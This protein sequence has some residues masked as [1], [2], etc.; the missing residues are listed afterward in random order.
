MLRLSVVNMSLFL[1]ISIARAAG[2]D[3]SGAG[4]PFLIATCTD[5]TVS[6]SYE[7]LVK[8]YATA[9]GG[10][11][12]P[13]VDQLKSTQGSWLD[14]AARV[15][16]DNAEPLPG[17][18]TLSESE[19]LAS[20]FEARVA[21]L[22]ASRMEGDYRFYPW[23]RYLVE[24]APPAGGV[25]IP[26][27]KHFETVMI[28]GFGDV[29]NA[30]NAMS[31]QLRTHIALEE[32]SDHL[33][34]GSS[35]KLTPGNTDLDIDS[36]TTVETVTMDRIS[37]ITRDEIYLHGAPHPNLFLSHRHFLIHE[38][39]LLTQ[40]DIFSGAD[41]QAVLGKFVVEKLKL[42]LGDGYF[43]SDQDVTA[44]AADPLHWDFSPEGLIVNFNPYE[45]ASYA[46]GFIAVTVPWSDL[47]SE[48]TKGALEIATY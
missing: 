35:E 22:E 27:T 16:G 48:M 36:S 20:T 41:W 45:V 23:E 13:I 11:S 3:C 5:R 32:T 24:K 44:T 25:D 21:A 7:T 39:R 26:S 38:G 31:A 17:D 4:S 34:V 18:F 37:L 42:E 14:Y 30:F 19:C 40:S 1:G 43:A 2:S 46:T 47:S 6:A 10:L 29:A 12:A 9:L 28:D 8:A 33:F 15:C